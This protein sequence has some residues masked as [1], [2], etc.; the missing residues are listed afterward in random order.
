MP[1]LGDVQDDK[2]IIEAQRRAQ[3]IARPLK[4]SQST[5]DAPQALTSYDLS[6][7]MQGIALYKPPGI[8]YGVFNQELSKELQDLGLEADWTARDSKL[9]PYDVFVRD[10]DPSTAGA[11]LT[12]GSIGTQGNGGSTGSIS[13]A[14]LRGGT[15]DCFV[16]GDS[17]TVGSGPY[18]LENSNGWNFS[19]DCETG[20]SPDVGI[21][22]LN[23]RNGDFGTAVVVNLGTNP[24]SR[25]PSDWMG[26]V[27]SILG[28]VKRVCWVTNVEWTPYCQQ[29]NDEIHNLA[30]R[31]P[32]VVVAD[33]NGLVQ[34]NR[35]LLA[36]DGVHST[37]DGYK[38]LAD[39]IT[40]ALGPAP[41]GG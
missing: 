23:A 20:R 29:V 16:V 8:T 36:G 37:P 17:I 5:Q 12:A 39:L 3:T 35:S 10:P 7:I 34:G 14:P 15:N 38:A 41:T 22:K 30:G 40:A 4:T 28:N 31:E 2:S 1:D 21:Q 33:R 26:E 25:A 6:S 11:G 9:T 18:L 13:P 24:S 19:I 32:K 27:M